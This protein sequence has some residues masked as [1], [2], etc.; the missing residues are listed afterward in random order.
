MGC[1]A[2]TFQ[3][4]TYSSPTQNVQVLIL[5]H[6]HSSDTGQ[7]GAEN[8]SRIRAGDNIPA[9][10]MMHP[11]PALPAPPLPET[12]YNWSSLATIG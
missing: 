3:Q 6:S 8:G 2:A 4:S 1:I 10:R 7:G 12:L 11:A 5:I 9:G